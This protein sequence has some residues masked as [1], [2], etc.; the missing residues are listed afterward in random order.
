MDTTAKTLEVGRSCIATQL[1][2]TAALPVMLVE[3]NLGADAIICSGARDFDDAATPLKH[4]D[5]HYLSFLSQP[6]AIS[7]TQAQTC[8]QVVCLDNFRNRCKP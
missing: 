6:D 3:L 1:F 5:E 2:N 4:H 7:I 8:V